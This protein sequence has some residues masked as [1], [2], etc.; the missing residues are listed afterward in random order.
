MRKVGS[1]RS[2]KI[3]NTILKN[4][5]HNNFLWLS[6]LL[7]LSGIYLICSVTCKYSLMS[8]D[9]TELINLIIQGIFS[10]IILL[11]FIEYIQYRRDKILLGFL[12]GTFYRKSI[13]QINE[14]GQRSESF[15]D[16]TRTEKQQKENI[17][18]IQ[19]SK[20]HNLKY[21]SC[22]NEKYIISLE[23]HGNGNYTGIAEYLDYKNPENTPYSEKKHKTLVDIIM[24]LNT[25]DNVSGK[26]SYKYQKMVDYGIYDFQII[27]KNKDEILIYY[28]NTIPSGL[29]EGYQIWKKL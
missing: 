9:Y 13:S 19:D 11:L 14:N 1:R 4:P 5:F 29:A 18:Y 22:E 2:N 16:K 28:K 25:P 21:Y 6:L 8:Q 26:G 3:E 10:S 27:G 15:D 24:S 12:A 23:Y 7:I 20:Y 17:E